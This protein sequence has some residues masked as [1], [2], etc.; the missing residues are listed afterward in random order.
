MIERRLFG[1]Y[2]ILKKLENYEKL[3]NSVYVPDY[4]V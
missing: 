2:V 1:V 3:N 4:L